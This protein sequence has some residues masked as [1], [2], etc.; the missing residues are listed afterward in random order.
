MKTLTQEGT[1]V[2]N[3]L[4]ALSPTYNA[5]K[6]TYLPELTVTRIKRTQ[7]TKVNRTCDFAL[8]MAVTLLIVV[9]HHHYSK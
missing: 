1:A 3:I 6:R 9:T 2:S 8:A 7:L 5:P 4:K